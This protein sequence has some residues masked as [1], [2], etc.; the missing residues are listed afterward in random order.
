MILGGSIQMS[1]SKKA[2]IICAAVVSYTMFF[3]YAFS[4]LDISQFSTSDYWG[5]FLFLILLVLVVSFPV[6]IR[7]TDIAFIQAVTVAIF[8][9]FGLLVEIILTQAA[10][11]IFL[12]KLH[13]KEWDRYVIN[14]TMFLITSVGSAAVF[15]LLGGELTAGTD[16][17]P[18][19]QLVPIIGYVFSFVFINHFILYFILTKLKNI[20]KDIFGHDFWWSVIPSLL[21]SPTGLLIYFLYGQLNNMAILFAMIPIVTS[22]VIFRL[23]SR[24][25]IVNMK[26]KTINETGNTMTEKLEVNHVVDEFVTAIVNLV[27]YEY[28]YLLTKDE[29][30]N[31]L[32]PVKL[33][34]AGI[35]AE[36]LERFLELEVAVGD[37]LSGRVA[38]T[39]K[40]FRIS[41]KMNDL[42]FQ[43]EPDFLRHQN[44]VLSVPL[45]RNKQV[46]GVITLS[47]KSPKKYTKEDATLVEILA[48]Q[49]AVALQ[50]ASE[51]ELTKRKSEVDE[52]TELYNYRY[53][54]HLLFDQLEKAKLEQ[55][56]LSLIILD[57]DYFK[58]FNDKYGHLAGNHILQ[59][60]AQLLKGE[61]GEYGLI[62]RYGGE[63]FTILLPDANLQRAS[64]IA[65]EIR[66]SVE[67]TS[68]QVELDLEEGES[69]GLQE[70]VNITVSIGVSNFPEHADD[71]LSLVRHADRAM[72]MGAK[73]K[74]R[75]KVAIYQAV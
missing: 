2:F 11:I 34:G 5:M 56:Q 7:G 50:N 39:G 43:G 27:P 26:L 22:T 17:A 66:Q 20:E 44:S 48:N 75:N 19:I 15:F 49:A 65:E 46:I 32:I 25:E 67:Q 54:E 16:G 60:L 73:R 53:F 45:I 62:S 30:G 61:I 69:R 70:K 3:L 4:N 8:L 40:S 10:V 14:G 18:E 58:Q 21:L 31:M 52:L 1:T 38:L 37:G 63:E 71:P 64:Q 35:T 51:Y 23:Y 59:S 74:G 33:I 57:I 24:L 13:S 42:H 41:D 6:N 55:R 29:E 47:Q 12:L 36:K 68:L 9:Q 72:Y 28:L